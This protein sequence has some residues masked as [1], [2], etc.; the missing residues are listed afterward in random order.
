MAGLA[1][2]TISSFKPYGFVIKDY[3]WGDA[4]DRIETGQRSST[5]VEVSVIPQS[6]SLGLLTL[7]GAG[8]QAWRAQRVPLAP[9]E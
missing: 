6:G 1:S 8:L 9:A 7:G 2:T 4:G 5:E 3:A